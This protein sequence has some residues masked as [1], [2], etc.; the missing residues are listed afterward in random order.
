MSFLTTHHLYPP[1]PAGARTAPLVSVSLAALEAGDAAASAA[2]F[3]ACKELGFFYLDLLGSELG[4]AIVRESE[5]LHA[6][7][8]EFFRLPFDV[9]NQYGRPHL[10]PFYAYRYYPKNI[11]DGNGNEVISESY[12]LRKDDVLGQCERL[13]CHPLILAHNDLYARYIL[14]C[15]GAVDVL[16]EHLN[17]HLELPAGT[18]AGLHRLTERSGD[19]VR[20]T[21]APP[22]PPIEAR[23]P[24]GEHTDF[25]SLT[26]LMNWLSGLQIRAPKTDEWLYVQPVPGSAVVNLGDALVTFT[27]GL[28][29]SNVHRVAP[30]IGAQAALDRYS[31]VFFARPEDKVVLRRLKGGL[32]DKQPA[33]EEPPEMTAAEWIMGKGTGTIPSVYTAENG[34][35]HKL[36]NANAGLVK[37]A[38]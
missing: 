11:K 35:E 4:E 13:A 18:L 23:A 21:H 17:R 6:L 36:G 24:G 30:A 22:L 19:H 25:G 2:F 16:L 37:A 33:R 1:F 34:L 20:F 3:A 10:D 12:N 5:E 26:L 31:L 28:L 8:Q 7:Q 38:A 27:A 15:R 32:I 29:R 9:K 14:H